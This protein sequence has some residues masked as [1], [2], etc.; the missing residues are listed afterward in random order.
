MAVDVVGSAVAEMIYY[1]MLVVSPVVR[2]TVVRSGLVV[3]VV[4]VVVQIFACCPEWIRDIAN[5]H[6]R[7]RSGPRTSS[8]HPSQCVG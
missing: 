2:A 6:C 4:A 8:V 3:L 1:A 7:G 5:I